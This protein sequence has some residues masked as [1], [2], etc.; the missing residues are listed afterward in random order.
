MPLKDRDLSIIA[1][2]VR[3]NVMNNS[4]VLQ[5][6]STYDKLDFNIL[7]CGGAP[8]IVLRSSGNELRLTS[9]FSISKTSLQVFEKVCFSKALRDFFAFLHIDEFQL[10]FKWD[11]DRKDKL[12]KYIIKIQAQDEMTGIHVW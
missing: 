8:G 10:I 4:R 11:E 3:G 2:I 9:K 12:F 6:L 7:V 1:K 5:P